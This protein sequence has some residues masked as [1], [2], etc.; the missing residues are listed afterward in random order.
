MQ[1][2]SAK[3]G[4]MRTIAE[5]QPSSNAL[6]VVMAGADRRVNKTQWARKGRG[7]YTC[8]VGVRLLPGESD[9][10]DQVCKL[11]NIGRSD[12]IRALVH[13]LGQIPL[14]SADYG[15][16]SP[17][18][19]SDKIPPVGKHRRTKRPAKRGKRGGR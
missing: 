15:D 4:H 18:P 10:L 17:P 3:E 16:V 2:P 8:F 19:E 12:F 11:L 7:A 14:K 5:S 6:E 1:Q 9:R 13:G